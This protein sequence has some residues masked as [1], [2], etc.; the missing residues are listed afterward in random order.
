MSIDKPRSLLRIEYEEDGQLK[1]FI[2]SAKPYT[3][4]SAQILGVVLL[5]CL[6]HR[7]FSHH[8]EVRAKGAGVLE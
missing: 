6:I 3:R 2:S 5:K 7:Q 8:L 1:I 4:R